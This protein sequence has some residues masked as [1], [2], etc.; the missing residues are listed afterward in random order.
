MRVAIF[1]TR[2]SGYLNACLRELASRPDVELL[3]V[4]EA[5]GSDAPFDDSQFAW[6]T[7]PIKWV[8]RP[9]RDTLLNEARAFGPDVLLVASW[10]IPA[11][12]YVL[13]RL[14]PRPLRILCM[15][16]QWRGTAKQYVGVITSP[17]FVR[18]MYD[19]AFLPGERQ[20]SFARRLGFSDNQIW[21]GSLCPDTAPLLAM[22]E[23]QL[24]PPRAFGYLGRLSPE[25]GVRDLLAAYEIYRR[26]GA[27]PWDLRVAGVGPLAGEVD[28]HPAVIKSGFVQPAALAQW[29][30]TIGCLVMPSRFEPWGVALSEGAVAGLPLIATAACGAVPH[31]VH[32]YANGRVARTGD[33]ES[34]VECMG[35][36]A[37]LSDRD[38]YA[39]GQVSRG[40][41]GPYT[42]ARWADTVVARSSQML[43]GRDTL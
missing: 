27:D 10:N 14:R 11:Y 22:A 8:G 33:V 40:L 20:A 41:A 21:Q 39:M 1:W 17:W 9:A 13:Q 43:A 34:L 38:R 37:G 35:H 7:A 16:N 3:V 12:R 18:R 36:I 31:L 2:L 24:A 26:T 32:D 6:M 5:P 19:A 29:M 4:H 15:D 28:R 23:T 25:K 30:R 42:P